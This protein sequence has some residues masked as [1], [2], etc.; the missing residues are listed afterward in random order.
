MRIGKEE[1]NHNTCRWY[2]C[3]HRKYNRMHK[4][5]GLLRECNKGAGYSNMKNWY[6]FNTPETTI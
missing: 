2:G 3:L 6:H 4:P 5:L 1:K